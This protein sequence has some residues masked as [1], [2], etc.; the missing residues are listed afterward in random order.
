MQAIGNEQTRFTDEA[1][2]F[3]STFRKHLSPNK[4][5]SHDLLDLPMYYLILKLELKK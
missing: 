3:S 5:T 4:A 2:Q 1:T